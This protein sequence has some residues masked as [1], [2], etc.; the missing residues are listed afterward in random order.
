MRYTRGMAKR[1]GIKTLSEGVETIEQVEFLKS[2]GCGKLQGYYFSKPLP[3][4]EMFEAMEKRN[5]TSEERQWRSFYEAAFLYRR[6]ER[7][8]KCHRSMS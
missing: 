5:I 3:L 8:L 2:I 4:L 7:S 1:I 6:I